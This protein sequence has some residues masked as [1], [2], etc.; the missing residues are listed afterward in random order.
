MPRGPRQAS[1]KSRTISRSFPSL[2]PAVKRRWVALMNI[3]HILCPVDLSE[4]SNHAI[5]QAVS[6]AGWYEARL[7]G[8]YV[9][10][11]MMMSVPS[12]AVPGYPADALSDEAPRRLAAAEMSNAFQGAVAAGVK[13]DV[14]VQT[15]QPATQILEC[16]ERL[17]ADLIVM[18][19]HGAGG[20]QH[21]L[22]G[23]VTEKVLRRASCPVLTVP[24]RAHVTSRLPFKHLLCAVDFS[25]SSLNALQF[26]FSLAQ[27]S[28]AALTI[29]H[30]LEWPWEEPPAPAFDQLPVE[31]AFSL[32][33]YRRDR[34]KQAAEQL[35]MLIPAAV[36]DW[37]IPKTRLEHGKPY[38]AILRVAKEESTDLIIIGVRGRHALDLMMFGS[39]T[40][41]VV[42]SATCPVLTHRR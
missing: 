20:F 33:M 3:K 16:A 39:T 36:R 31:Q 32:A 8:F 27:E 15:G 19:T 41:H 9:C 34:E 1:G 37:C 30:T 26:A 22:L 4:A 6:I 11:P 38:A 24:P 14:L 40:N 2:K 35:E 21:L 23:S 17:P 13:V 29:L 5:D 42:R 7:T 10:T 12:L 28:D 25:E 18:G